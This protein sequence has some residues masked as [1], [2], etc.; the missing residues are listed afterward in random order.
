MNDAI[1]ACAHLGQDSDCAGSIVECVALFAPTDVR[2]IGPFNSPKTNIQI[3][4]RIPGPINSCATLTNELAQQ[5]GQ[6]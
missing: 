2:P 1:D 6:C 3:G 4:S 5:I